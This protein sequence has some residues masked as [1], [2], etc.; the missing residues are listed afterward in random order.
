MTCTKSSSYLVISYEFFIACSVVN[1]PRR[2]IEPRFLMKKLS[3]TH[4]NVK[5]VNTK[6]DIIFCYAASNFPKCRM[7]IFCC[8]KIIC[9]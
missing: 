7:I 3:V 9:I 1:K 6:D 4:L 5:D 2:K 8:S